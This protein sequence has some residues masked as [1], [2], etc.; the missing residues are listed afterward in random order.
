MLYFFVLKNP[1]H[2]CLPRVFATLL[3]AL[4]KLAPII[5]F[6][7]SSYIAERPENG[8]VLQQRLV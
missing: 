1:S 7:K 6:A 3:L 2:I 8:G 5:N 4:E